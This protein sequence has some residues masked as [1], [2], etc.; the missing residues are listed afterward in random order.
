MA[1]EERRKLKKLRRKPSSIKSWVLVI[2]Y[3]KDFLLLR[4]PDERVVWA[5][6]HPYGTS[7]RKKSYLPW[8]PTYVGM[9]FGCRLKGSFM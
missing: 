2:I 5:T 8:I 6:R 1:R 3:G 9:T 7:I 4:N